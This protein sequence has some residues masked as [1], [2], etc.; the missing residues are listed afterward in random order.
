MI[1]KLTGLETESEIQALNFPGYWL[2]S[3]TGITMVAVI[4]KFCQLYVS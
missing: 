4:H 2:G 3:G 1:T